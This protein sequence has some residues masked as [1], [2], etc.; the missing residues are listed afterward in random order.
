MCFCAPSST[1]SAH[2]SDYISVRSI[3]EGQVDVHGV[4]ACGQGDTGGRT[5]AGSE[6]LELSPVVIA[7]DCHSSWCPGSPQVLLNDCAKAFSPHWVLFWH[8][9]CK[10]EHVI[11]ASVWARYFC[12]YGKKME[13]WTCWSAGIW[14]SGLFE[15]MSKRNLN[16]SELQGCCVYVPDAPAHSS[17]HP[18]QDWT[19]SLFTIVS[20]TKSECL[21]IFYCFFNL[22]NLQ[23]VC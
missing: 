7:P 1:P 22:Y 11:L 19:I 15:V 14:Q 3:L 4:M 21:W 20:H 5:L 17:I 23:I 9:L 16:T 2:Q 12:I 18:K 8:N 6:F 13:I 10:S